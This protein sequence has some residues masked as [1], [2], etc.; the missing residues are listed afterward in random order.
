MN[1]SSFMLSIVIDVAV[2]GG[3]LFYIASLLTYMAKDPEPTPIWE[4]I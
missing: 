3:L 2:I 1:E 4:I